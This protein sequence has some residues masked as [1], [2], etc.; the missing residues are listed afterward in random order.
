MARSILRRFLNVYWLRPET[1]LWRT[2]MTKA[3]SVYKLKSPSMDLACGDGIL[4]Y[5]TNGGDFDISFDMFTCVDTK[6]FYNNKD[7]YDYYEKNRIKPVVAKKPDFYFDVGFDWKVNLLKRARELN[8]YGHLV[9]GT[10]DILPFKDNTFATIFSNSVYWFPSLE[11]S[12]KEIHR[13]LKNDGRAI[14]VVQSDKLKEYMFCHK[15][16]KKYKARGNKFLANLFKN[17][18]R[19]RYDCYVSSYNIETWKKHLKKADLKLVSYVPCISRKAT[20]IWDIGLRP[21]S[22]YTIRIAEYLKKIGLKKLVKAISIFLFGLVLS[23]YT[24]VTTK[25]D[26][27]YPPSY[28]ILEVAKEK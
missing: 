25:E 21:I 24:Q 6:G 9:Q 28:F 19:G 17:L 13:V 5:V 8:Y 15:L 26:K 4:S 12:L 23:R 10:G 2:I 14:L 18:D 27:K 20:Y 22:P 11:S 3:M 16:Y 7:I 1:A